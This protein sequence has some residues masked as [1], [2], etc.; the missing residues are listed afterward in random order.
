[1]NYGTSSDKSI[2]GSKRGDAIQNELQQELVD[3]QSRINSLRIELQRAENDVYKVERLWNV[4]TREK[5]SSKKIA[6]VVYLM[7]SCIVPDVLKWLLR[8]LTRNLKGIFRRLAGPSQVAA[9]QVRMASAAHPQFRVLHAIANFMTGGSSRLVVDIVEGL[10][11]IYHQEILTGFI[12]VPNAYQGVAVHECRSPYEIVAFLKKFQP[13]VLHVHYWGDVDFGWYDKVFSAAEEIGCKVVENVNTPVVPYRSQI[14]Q[15]Y[16]YVSDYVMRSFGR[17]GESGVVIHP[18]S[19]VNF[20]SRKGTDDIPEN[21][22]G[23]VYRLESDKLSQQS[24]DVF[25]EVAKRRPNTKILIVGDGSFLVTYKQAVLAHGVANSFAFTGAVPYGE[26]PN[27]YAQMSVFVAPVWKES[28]GQVSSFAMSMGIPVVGYKVGGLEE[29][30][31]DDELLVAVGDI[32]R[33]ASII[34]KL[35]DDR[36][37]RHLIGERNRLRAESLFPV[38]QMIKKYDFLYRSMIDERK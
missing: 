23:M 15:H 31:D 10:G 1:M 27:I 21:C 18:G 9:Y 22:I 16:V 12:P 6:M 32:D 26:L 17:S 28:F 4:L 2:F 30:V 35:L 38:E 24:I 5:R 29:I 20:F 19:E 34:I 37:M 11:H 25:I 7:I 14:V 3:S 36:E 8:P 33:L 13:D